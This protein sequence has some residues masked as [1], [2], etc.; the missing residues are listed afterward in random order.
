[1]SS[2]KVGKGVRNVKSGDRVVIPSTIACGYCSYCRAGY[3]ANATTQSQRPAGR[4][5]VFRWTQNSG[6]FMDC[7]PNSRAFHS[8]TLAWSSFLRGHRRPGIL[9]SDIFPTGYFGA[10][11]ANIHPGAGRGLWLRACRPFVIASA[12]LFGAGRIIA[13]DTISTRLEMA[14]DQ[15]AEIIDFSST[16]P[17]EAIRE[18]TGG[19]GCGSRV[20]AVASMPIV[21]RKAPRTIARRQRV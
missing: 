16:D 6:P 20:D 18:L 1:V 10:E 13:I 7:K 21:L 19:I 17:I 9:T 5:R 14:Q 12:K 2:K 4:H 11:I 3:Y 15:G 8:Q